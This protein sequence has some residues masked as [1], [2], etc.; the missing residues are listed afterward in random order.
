MSV[1]V[2]II[3]DEN[4]ARKRLIQ[5]LHTFF[6][7][8]IKILGDSGDSEKIL[9]EV[10]KLSPDI[11]FLDVEMPG[12]TGLEMAGKL[13]AKGF[14]GKIIFVTAY[15]HYAIKAIRAG[16]Y[17][18]LLKPVDVDELKQV[19]RCGYYFNAMLNYVFYFDLGK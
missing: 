13:K 12:I 4:L 19:R 15:D 9:E 16:A 2:Y 11:L 7:G 8:D 3:D 1:S 10:P 5:L 6:N 18:Y 14:N 17:D